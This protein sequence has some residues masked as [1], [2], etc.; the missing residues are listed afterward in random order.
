MTGRSEIV[1]RAELLSNARGQLYRD[2]YVHGELRDELSSPIG[3]PAPFDDV[4]LHERVVTLRP[5]DD[6]TDIGDLGDRLLLESLTQDD[7]P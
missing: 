7:A 4:V 6:S 1:Y 3:S 5:T 2:V